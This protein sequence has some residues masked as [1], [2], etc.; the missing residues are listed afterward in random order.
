MRSVSFGARP[1]YAIAV[2][3]PAGSNASVAESLQARFEG[4]VRPM[5]FTSG[6]WFVPMS[7]WKPPIT[8]DLPLGHL[9]VA[10]RLAFGG[11]FTVAVRVTTP[12]ANAM[13]TPPAAKQKTPAAAPTSLRRA[14]PPVFILLP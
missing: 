1:Q 9:A 3:S 8:T 12:L 10:A 14:R 5:G 4:R 2:A 11:T 13:P 6:W 7:L